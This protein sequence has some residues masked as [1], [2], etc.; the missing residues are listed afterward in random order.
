MFGLLL[1]AAAC[2]SGVEPAE[3]DEPVATTTH[4][5][6]RVERSALIGAEDE[7]TGMAFAGVVRV[8]ET[9]DPEPLLRL[10]GRGL[11]LPMAGQCALSSRERDA[12]LASNVGQAE[13]LDAGDVLLRA[14]EAETLLAPRLFESSQTE[15]SGVVYTSRDRAS[16][17]LPGGAP[18]VLKTSGSEQLPALELRVQ[19]PELLSDVSVGGATL[20][21]V[22]QV[23]VASE[24]AVS[25]RPGD[26]RDV[27]YVEVT[28]AEAG[29]LGVCA[30][31]D[32]DGGGA[33]PRGLFGVSGAGS[34]A[35]HRLREVAADVGALDAAEVRFDF[36]LTAE[37]S[38]H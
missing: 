36:E 16:E 25:W 7:A 30:F 15:L 31:R 28:G 11:T 32:S 3:T 33:L 2:G 14:S 20:A 8:P 35:F 29:T 12:M 18:Y 19:A 9:A 1:L 38:F 5:L 24:L 13:F 27:V 10:S 26:A 21:E 23:A 4:A 37:V 22:S 17:P 6:L 34:L